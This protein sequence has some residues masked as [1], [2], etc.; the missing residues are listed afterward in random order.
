MDKGSFSVGI[1][2][3]Y[4]ALLSDQNKKYNVS[5]YYKD[6]KQ[7][8]SNYQHLSLEEIDTI[9]HKAN[10]YINTDTAKSIKSSHWTS[11]GQCIGIGDLICI[12]LYCDYTA[13]SSDFTLSFRKK[14][15]FELLEQI[16]K[17]NS[18]YFWWSNILKNTIEQFGSN[19]SNGNGIVGPFYCGMSIILTI[20]QFNMF[21]HSPTSTS[22]QISV[23]IKFASSHGM[24]LEMD[25]SKGYAKDLKGFD[26]SW[27]SRFRE[28]D[29][30]Y[31]ICKLSF[32]I[33]QEL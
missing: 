27:I 25:N 31:I 12:I 15:E 4:S 20:T 10:Q 16:K 26:C 21:I 30:R 22:T 18:R 28:E 24:I 29:E 23:A 32:F 6:L 1:P 3:T 8:M 2:W 7:E 17:R 14:N 5:A 33:L 9:V 11:K 13:L 19:Y